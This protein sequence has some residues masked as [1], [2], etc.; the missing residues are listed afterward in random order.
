M[1]Q[2][3]VSTAMFFACF[4]F[5]LSCGEN[6]PSDTPPLVEEH[7]KPSQQLLEKKEQLRELDLSGKGYKSLTGI[8]QLSLLEKLNLKENQLSELPIEMK[9]LK[10]LK[11]LSLANNRLESFP[12]VLIEMENLREL[13]LRHNQLK[14]LPEEIKNMK[15]LATIYVGNNNLNEEQRILIREWLPRVQVIISN[16]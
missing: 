13:D 10:K 2:Q 12:K 8:G 16:D 15:K 4:L 6:P 5:L 14:E 3:F 9:E 11:K 1:Y 7:W